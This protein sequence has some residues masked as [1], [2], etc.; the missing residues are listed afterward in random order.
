MW[1]VKGTGSTLIA[2]LKDASVVGKKPYHLAEI[3]VERD[4]ATQG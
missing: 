1:M 3:C 2:E 4:Y